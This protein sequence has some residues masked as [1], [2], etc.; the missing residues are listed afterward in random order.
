MHH[1]VEHDVTFVVTTSQHLETCLQAVYVNVA[2][3]PPVSARV[4]FARASLNKAYPAVRKHAVVETC[5][6]LGRG[7]VDV[8]A[9]N[10]AIFWQP[11][12]LTCRPWHCQQPRP[13]TAHRLCGCS[14]ALTLASPMCVQGPGHREGI[15]SVKA[16][17]AA[18]MQASSLDGSV[19]HL[20]HPCKGLKAF[21]SK[22]AVAGHRQLLLFAHVVLMVP[23]HLLCRDGGL[24]GASGGWAQEAV[25]QM[26][27]APT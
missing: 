25:R 6:M 3:A 8:G 9:C 11:S 4:A 16:L 13:C 26:T 1:H 27:A 7:I 23:G 5:H 17:A 19:H 20:V 22:M 10:S 12:L 14:G 21:G 15:C 2:L 24:Q 18:V